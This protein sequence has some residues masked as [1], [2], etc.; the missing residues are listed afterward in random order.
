MAESTSQQGE[1]VL[2]SPISTSK[3]RGEGVSKAQTDVTLKEGDY[4]VTLPRA[5]AV[6][7]KSDKANE[8]NSDEDSGKYNVYAQ[9]V[10][11]DS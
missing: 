11:N 3:K 9:I 8:S 4:N 5:E 10:R 2:S 1:P 7:D 6:E